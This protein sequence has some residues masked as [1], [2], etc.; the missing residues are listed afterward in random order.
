MA[1]GPRL[2]IATEQ[3]QP[4]WFF[5]WS[6]QLVLQVIPFPL[7]AGNVAAFMLDESASVCKP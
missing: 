2:T 7:V 6:R 1:Q 3:H 5:Q 4:C